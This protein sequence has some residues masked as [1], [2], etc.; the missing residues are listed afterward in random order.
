MIDTRT[1]AARC[2]AVGCHGYVRPVSAAVD[3]SAISGFEAAHAGLEAAYI[4]GNCSVVYPEEDYLELSLDEFE[5][6]IK[7]AS[8]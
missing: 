8:E 1:E 4:C 7:P 6:R 5:G 3:Q 2:K